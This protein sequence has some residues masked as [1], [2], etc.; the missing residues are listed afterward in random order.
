MKSPVILKQKCD[1]DQMIQIEIQNVFE[2]TVYP[3][4]T[5]LTADG[6]QTTLRARSWSLQCT[7]AAAA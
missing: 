1:N 4:A 5:V 7:A 6:K 3:T 2:Y